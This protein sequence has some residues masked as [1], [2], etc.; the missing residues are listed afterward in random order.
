MWTNP[1]LK[2][3]IASHPTIAIHPTT[4]I[5]PKISNLCTVP[6]FNWKHPGYR[7]KRLWRIIKV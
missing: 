7:P 4:A 5:H 3:E 2:K 6:R 1:D